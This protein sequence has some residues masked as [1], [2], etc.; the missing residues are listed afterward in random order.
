MHA[1]L[2]YM[3]KFL[4]M[5][6]KF[7][8]SFKIV[9]QNTKY[10]QYHCKYELCQQR[11]QNFFKFKKHIEKHNCVV[12]NQSNDAV[13][14]EPPSNKKQKSELPHCSQNT[15]NSSIDNEINLVYLK[16]NIEKNIIKFVLSFHAKSNFVRKN[17]PEILKNVKDS[18]IAPLLER[19]SMSLMRMLKIYLE[20][21]IPNLNFSNICNYKI[22]TNSHNSFL[23]VVS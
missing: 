7:S 9:S 13:A 23:L 11:F 12:I 8:F 21:L 1:Y 5:F 22:Y 4:P 14:I 6:R 10:F 17:I 18:V 16:K 2:L 3:S 19:L 20:I 15:I